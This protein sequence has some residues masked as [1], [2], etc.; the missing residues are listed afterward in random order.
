MDRSMHESNRPLC[1]AFQPDLLDQRDRHLLRS[2]KRLE[3]GSARDK[4]KIAWR[5][6]TFTEQLVDC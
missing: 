3:S 1:L 5:E 2:R 6:R 4:G